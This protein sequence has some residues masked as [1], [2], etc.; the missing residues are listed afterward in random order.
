MTRFP[1]GEEAEKAT[2]RKRLKREKNAKS[3]VIPESMRGTGDYNK[4][5]PNKV[6]VNP[7]VGKFSQPSD[8]TGKFGAAK[9]DDE[10]LYK[11]KQQEKKDAKKTPEQ[12]KRDRQIRNLMRGSSIGK[13]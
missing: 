4:R 2:E 11:K 1:A 12:L 5:N 3:D 10:E 6:V 13:N 8:P 9:M 7:R